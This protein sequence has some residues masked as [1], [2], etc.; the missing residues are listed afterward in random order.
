MFSYEIVGR[1]RQNEQGVLR[2]C[3][4]LV[5]KIR[6][7]GRQPG[8][9]SVP[10]GA[11]RGIDCE[12]PTKAG[13]LQVQVTR[14]ATPKVWQALAMLGRS[15]RTLSA[16]EAVADLL[17]ALNKK[18]RKFSR[19]D[20]RSTVLAIDATETVVHSM[21]AVVD[22]IRELHQPGITQVGFA[23]VWVIGPHVEQVHRLD[24]SRSV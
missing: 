6:A 12:I 7:D 10:S 22:K 2:V 4:L 11:E 20:R 13:V 9:A 23:E 15:S 5:E 18:A 19:N 17:Q 8:I 14:P 3:N 24:V 21:R 1:S 16:D